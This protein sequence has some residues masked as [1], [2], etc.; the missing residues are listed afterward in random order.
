MV[1]IYVVLFFCRVCKDDLDELEV[2]GKEEQS[3]VK[4][5]SYTFEVSGRFF[6]QI[7]YVIIV[8]YM[9]ASEFLYHNNLC[10]VHKEHTQNYQIKIVKIL[11]CYFTFC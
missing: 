7:L 10:I 8:Y 5:T 1:L 11:Q 9:P 3:G 2:Y 6:S 4:L